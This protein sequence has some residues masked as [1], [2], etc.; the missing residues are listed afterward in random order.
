MSTAGNARFN[1]TIT[2]PITEPSIRERAAPIIHEKC[3]V[4]ASCGVYDTLQRWQYR[5]RQPLGLS[6]TSLV[7]SEGELA[8]LRMLLPEPDNVG[9]ALSSEQH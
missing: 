4:A 2:E 5:Q 7:L 1:A 9:A 8:S 6:V 3:E